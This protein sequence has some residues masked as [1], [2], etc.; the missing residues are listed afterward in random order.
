MQVF[1]FYSLL[2]G[3]IICVEECFNQDEINCNCT[4]VP[5]T[6]LVSNINTEFKLKTIDYFDDNFV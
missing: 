2:N 1:I 6:I 4:T 3:N 5:G